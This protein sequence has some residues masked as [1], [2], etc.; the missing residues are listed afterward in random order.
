MK[1]L[2]F[3]LF[4]SFSIAKAQVVTVSPAYPSITDTITITFNASQ[5][6]AALNNFIG[7]VYIHT[8][9]INN[10]SG[11]PS[12]WSYIKR[13]WSEVDSTQLMTSMGNNQYKITFRPTQYYGFGT[14]E[15]VRSLGM[16][17]RNLAGNLV[18]KNAD[19]S[20]IFVPIFKSGYSAA[21]ASPVE[22]VKS[23]S[24]GETFQFKVKTKENSFINLFRDNQVIAQVASGT[25]ATATI[26]CTTSGKFWLKYTAQSGANSTTDSI[27]YV[28]RPAFVA[29]DPPPGIKEGINYLPGDTSV[30]FMLRAPWKDHAYVIGDFNDWQVDLNYLMKRASD[31]ERY[32]LQVD[33]FV[34]QTEYRMQYYVDDHIRI[35][36]PYSEK[37]LEQGSD[38]AINPLIYP[39]LIPFPTGKTV[40]KVTVFQTAEPEYNWQVTNFQ[41]PDSR[42]L[43]I[44]ECLVR[45]FVNRHDFK[46]I[47]DSIKY[48][49]NLHVNAVQFMPVQE[50]EGNNSWGYSPTYFTAIDKYY[51]PRE[52]LKELIDT[53]HRNGIAV[54]FDVVFNHAFGQSPH[55]KLWWDEGFARPATDN[56]YLNPIAK[57]P[58]NVGYDYNHESGYTK[59]FMDSVV[60]YLVK[61]YKIDGYRFDLSKGFTQVDSGDDVGAWGSYDQSRVNLLERMKNQ[62]WARNP[63]L[64]LILEHLGSNVEESTL[65][66]MGFML[67][68]KGTYEFSQ[69]AMGFETGSNFNYAL[70]YQARNFAFHNL[71]SYAVSHDEERIMYT[72]RNFGNSSGSY[73]TRSLPTALERNAQFVPYL[74]LTPGP[75][76]WWMFDE[77]G[78]DVSIN[79]GGRT[80]PKPIRWWEYINQVD[81]L[82]LYKTYAAFAKLKTSNPSYRTNNFFMSTGG[83]EKQLY[84]N[85]ASMKTVVIGNF[86]VVTRDVFTGFPN[87]G[88]WYDYMTGQSLQVND[89]SMTISLAPGKYKVYTSAQQPVP[90]MTLITNGIQDYS[91]TSLASSVYPNPFEYETTISFN[92][93]SPS[94]TTIKIYD[95]TGK[96][97]TTLADGVDMFGA[98]NIEWDGTNLFGQ[99]VSNGL[100]LYEINSGNRISTG[101]L[102]VQRLN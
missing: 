13:I 100:Y 80:S 60:D 40:E 12:D 72:V 53:L 58:F 37:V 54:I 87:T 48:F 14:T 20:D 65:A 59:F 64:Y 21:I 76:M 84:I 56:P 18:G 17:F 96:V 67:W 41:K 98:Q 88:T 19:N 47:I 94:K 39:N 85:D 51:G 9:I 4:A 81:R 16:I 34:P 68:G 74:L 32:W 35:G 61:E 93:D 36:D 5:G 78:Y 52:K 3:I 49:K 11:R 8:G 55:A 77:L 82:R 90:D 1:K 10:F 7:D 86:D 46:S 69:A 33:G 23:A 71:V 102:S 91:I 83:K 57:H 75:K 99:K 79:F 28:V 6:N 50:F 30:V 70:N 25:E 27:Y 45:D 29:Q 26:N 73:N 66:G 101:K 44:Y 95:I 43:V 2:I 31:G 15:K 92:L 63:G 62:A 22:Q 42:D 97:V 38:N 24:L 89:V